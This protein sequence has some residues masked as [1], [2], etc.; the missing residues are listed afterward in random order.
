MK[1]LKLLFAIF[2]AILTFSCKKD[3]STP[4]STLAQTGNVVLEFQTNYQD[5]ELALNQEYTTPLPMNQK[6][7]FSRFSY[8]I[9]DISLINNNGREVKY[10]HANPDKGAF[11]VIYYENE[12]PKKIE[13][14]EIPAGN[15]N[16]IKFRLGISNET[17]KLGQNKQSAF[18]N[19]SKVANMTW[20]NWEKGYKHIYF[21]GTWGDESEKFEVQFGNVI[22]ENTERSIE[23]TLPLPENL[24]LKTGETK[25][26]RFDV[27]ASNIFGGKN[28]IK[29]TPENAVINNNTEEE[30]IAKIRENIS[31][32]VFKVASVY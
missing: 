14:K 28:K 3:D 19:A 15:Y 29:L 8:I 24:I 17:L 1:N 25:D 2:I 4:E 9:S 18:W 13:L 11:L 21:E 6:I 10:H 31:S 26:V 12:K 20:D 27:N 5:G 16:K 32:A 22:S 7:R 23:L 30:M